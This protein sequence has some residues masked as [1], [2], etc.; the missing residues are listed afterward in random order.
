MSGTP[1]H[2]SDVDSLTKVVNTQAIKPEFQFMLEPYLIAA[3]QE[4]GQEKGCCG[5]VHPNDHLVH[6]VVTVS[7]RS[8]EKGFR[9]GLGEYFD[10]GRLD[11]EQ[12]IAV[13]RSL[14]H[15]PETS[16]VLEFAAGYG[17]VTRHIHLP[18]F[19]ASD[20]HADAI[21]FL[22]ETFGVDAQRSSEAPDLFNPG[23]KF[24]F[25]FV[26]SLFSHLSDHVFG[27]WLKKLYSLLKPGGHLMFTTYGVSGAAM[28][29]HLSP[30][31][32]LTEDF[33]FFP[34]LTDQPDLDRATY[35]TMV[36][37]ETY[38]RRKVTGW[39]N[40]NIVSFKE[41]AWWLIQDEWVVANLCCETRC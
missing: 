22:Q 39:T 21:P 9:V 27:P 1:R 17:R 4:V 34:E 35:G 38:V 40:G 20:I 13:M 6:Y 12:A 28:D 8:I 16:S 15:D 24:D 11:A 36:A 7:P 14:G 32:P 18:N 10:R 41:N 33:K 25:I 2:T 26:L 23:R 3:A 37:T 30:S 31:L 5:I 19:M 29:K